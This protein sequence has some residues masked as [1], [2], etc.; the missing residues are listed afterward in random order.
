MVVKR[1]IDGE[2]RNKNLLGDMG[3]VAVALL[4]Q[5]IIKYKD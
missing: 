2:A 1:K 3:I 5:I 4:S